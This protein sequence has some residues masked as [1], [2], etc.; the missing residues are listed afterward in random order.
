MLRQ[1]QSEIQAQIEHLR[2]EADGIMTQWWEVHR[3]VGAEL[4]EA[5][6]QAPALLPPLESFSRLPTPGNS[7]PKLQVL[8]LRELLR[9]AMQALAPA[10]SAAA[11]RESKEAQGAGGLRTAK[12]I[13]AALGIS[14]KTIYR[15]VK[16]GHM[17][18][19]RIQSGL[20][21]RP[22]EI[23]AWLESKSFQPAGMKKAPPGRRIVSNAAWKR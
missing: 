12:E 3:A 17:P 20:R 4:A 2:C 16:E 15:L 14:D 13:A 6:R 10:E 23:E 11:P 18:Y 22:A 19:V 8:K 5:A 1:T 21:F 7:H 9:S